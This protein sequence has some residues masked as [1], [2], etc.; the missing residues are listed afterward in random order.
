[1]KNHIL[2]GVLTLLTA[3]TTGCATAPTAGS[4]G[5]F[6]AAA[7]ES[8]AFDPENSSIAYDPKFPD[9]AYEQA[10]GH[11]RDAIA[12]EMAARGLAAADVSSA[13]LIVSYSVDGFT[14]SYELTDEVISLLNRGVGEDVSGSAFETTILGTRLSVAIVD[15]A[16][17]ASVF[18]REK[19]L[20]LPEAPENHG[21]KFANKAVADLF[22]GR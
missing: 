1:M 13:D 6:D 9:F 15:R 2:L 10:S 8:Y 5:A 22:A 20:Y 16:D 3:F 12:S 17:G 4:S 18:N 19:T 7:Y 11:V 14:T 21:G